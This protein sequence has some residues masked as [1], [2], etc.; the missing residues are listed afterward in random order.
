MT[1]EET[2]VQRL[3][4]LAKVVQPEVVEVRSELRPAKF[5]GWSLLTSTAASCCSL[6]A[7]SHSESTDPTQLLPVL[8]DDAPRKAIRSQSRTVPWLFSCLGFTWHPQGLGPQTS[9]ISTLLS[10]E[11]APT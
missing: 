4:E 1:D 10:A 8:T 7:S 9:S 11:E 2:D 6:A 5:Q 3:N